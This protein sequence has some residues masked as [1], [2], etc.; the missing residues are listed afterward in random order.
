VVLCE[1][2]HCAGAHVAG[3]CRDDAFRHGEEYGVARGVTHAFDD[4]SLE[5]C[6]VCQT[7]QV[8]KWDA[9]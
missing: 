7:L 8:R 1:I 4:Q 9:E 3:G 2:P 5:V 6:G